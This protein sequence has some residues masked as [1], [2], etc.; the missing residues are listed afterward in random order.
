MVSVPYLLALSLTIWL[1]LVLAALAVPNCGL[2]FLQASVSVLLEDQFSPGGI[3]VWRAVAHGQL[4]GV[5]GNHKDS[6]PGCSLVPDGSG[7]V[8]RGPGI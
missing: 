5:E 1:S 3:W 4:Q 2:S 6:V 8:T 7:Q